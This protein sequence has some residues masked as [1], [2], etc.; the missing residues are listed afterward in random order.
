M[1]A[2]QNG[3]AYDQVAV[4]VSSGGYNMLSV[5]DWKKLDIVKRLSLMKDGKVTFLL[6]GQVASI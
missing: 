5:N 6:N 3:D 2:E 4:K 1:G